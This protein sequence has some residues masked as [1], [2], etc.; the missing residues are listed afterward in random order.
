[1][2]FSKKNVLVATG[3]IILGAL[4]ILAIR[5]A[6]YNPHQVHY[7]ANFALYINGQRETFNEPTYYEE[8]AGGSCTADENIT[9][10]ERAH[11]HDSVSDLVHVHDHAVTWGAFFQNINWAIGEDFV[12]TPLKTYVADDTHKVNFYLN[13]QPVGDISN[14]VIKDKDRLLVDFGTTSQADLQKEADSV[15]S[16]AVQADAG[17]D[18][19]ACMGNKKLTVSD[20]LKH[21]FN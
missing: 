12:K 15:A 14:Q 16:S 8:I 10:V 20:R 3:G 21:L 9:P 7:H 5:F 2:R 13:G 17:N 11:M 1:M 19:A 4:A 6:T 18:P